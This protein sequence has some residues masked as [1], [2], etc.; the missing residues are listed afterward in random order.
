MKL[1]QSIRFS[2]LEIRFGTFIDAEILKLHVTK[3]TRCS[4]FTR[5][6]LKL[7]QTRNMPINGCARKAAYGVGQVMAVTPFRQS[8]WNCEWYWQLWVD[9]TFGMQLDTGELSRQR[10]YHHDKHPIGA[11]WRQISTNGPKYLCGRQTDV[12]HNQSNHFNDAAADL[13]LHTRQVLS[14]SDISLDSVIDRFFKII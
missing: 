10:R 2:T 6:S 8:G 1:K 11:N 3:F 5:C 13:H 12:L 4:F 14:R 7:S 9:L